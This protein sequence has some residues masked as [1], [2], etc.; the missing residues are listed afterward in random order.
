MHRDRRRVGERIDIEPIDVTW[1]PVSTPSEGH[2]WLRQQDGSLVEIS[3]TG[4]RMVTAA[5][6]PVDIGVW[7][8]LDVEGDCAVVAVR[9][10]TETTDSAG[11]VFD[12]AFVMLAPT[13]RDRIDC[14]IATRLG[15]RGLVHGSVTP[16]LP[17]PGRPRQ[18]QPA[19]T[20]NHTAMQ[21]GRGVSG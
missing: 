8:E 3:A 13:L 20:S 19:T 4:A 18:Q 15:H 5:R 6:H 1:L 16:L 9:R 2:R 21:G 17:A 14:T 12:V 7:I 10:V 11:M